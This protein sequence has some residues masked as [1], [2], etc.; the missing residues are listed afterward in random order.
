MKKLIFAVIAVLGM[1]TGLVYAGTDMD[2][3]M[4]MDTYEYNIER[5]YNP[6]IK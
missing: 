3:E 4:K 2:E 6:S 5:V 1:S